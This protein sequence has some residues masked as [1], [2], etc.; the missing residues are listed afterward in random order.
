ME[1]FIDNDLEKALS[2]ESDSDS[3]DEK[4]SNE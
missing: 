4:E 3:N 1:K 2:D